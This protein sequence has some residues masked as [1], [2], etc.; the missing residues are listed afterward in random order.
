MAD[1]GIA[2]WLFNRSILRD[3]TMTLLE[4]PAA[5]KALGV[6]TIELVSSFFPNQTTQY[7]PETPA[8]VPVEGGTRRPHL[9]QIFGHRG[10]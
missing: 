5:C 3:K 1:F 4:M 6:E 8:C 2:G 10:L 7:L 9:A